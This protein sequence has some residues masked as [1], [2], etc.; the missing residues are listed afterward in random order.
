VFKVPVERRKGI[1]EAD[2][3]DKQTLHAT[4][5]VKGIYIQTGN[6]I[7]KNFLRK[8][9]LVLSQFNKLITD[10]LETMDKLLFLQAEIE[11]C[12]AIETQLAELQQQSKL[13]SIT[14]EIS[15][16]KEEL[17]KIQKIFQEQTIEVIQTYSEEKVL[18]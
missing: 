11:R 8:R 15:L 4:Q 2:N 7:I 14:E 17:K 5:L 10:Q 12:Q 6:L 3:A 18:V 1:Q 13:D 9:V 16:M